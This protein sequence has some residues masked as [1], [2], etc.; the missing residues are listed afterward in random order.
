MPSDQSPFGTHLIFSFQFIISTHFFP[1]YRSL[2]LFLYYSGLGVGEKWV[3][4]SW[5]QL[6][7]LIV[8]L[9]GSYFY[10]GKI[11]TYDDVEV[12]SSGKPISDPTP[13]ELSTVALTRS[14]ALTPRSKARRDAGKPTG[15]FLDSEYELLVKKNQPQGNNAYKSIG[16]YTNNRASHEV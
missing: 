9:F 5:L 6:A 3:D 7:G 12:D 13:A 14:P 10:Q 15:G 4:A 2:G 16:N 8:L 11:Y 1:L